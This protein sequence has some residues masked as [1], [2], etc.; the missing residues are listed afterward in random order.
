MSGTFRENSN[1]SLCHD[2]CI[3]KVHVALASFSFV[4]SALQVHFARVFSLKN[5]VFK[6]CA[7][8]VYS[9]KVY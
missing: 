2:N 3:L 1:V 5:F 8:M 7:F 6:C 9:K 4:N